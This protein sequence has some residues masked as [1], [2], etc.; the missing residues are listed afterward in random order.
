MTR[1]LFGESLESHSRS[2]EQS[3]LKIRHISK[4]STKINSCA[5]KMFSILLSTFY[6]II[7]EKQKNVIQ[8]NVYF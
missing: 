6:D 8:F 4:H 1:Q 3:C 7:S 5:S 2:K